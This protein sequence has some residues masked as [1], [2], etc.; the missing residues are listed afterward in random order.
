MDTTMTAT[1]PSLTYQAASAT[2][3][4]RRIPAWEQER[5]TSPS[6]RRL[7]ERSQLS[8]RWSELARRLE[9]QVVAAIFESSVTAG[10]ISE[11]SPS[12]PAE[13]P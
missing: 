4:S 1:L 8:K 9:R 13:S 6:L 3:T 11:C 7:A 5:D 10:A 2:E 12:T